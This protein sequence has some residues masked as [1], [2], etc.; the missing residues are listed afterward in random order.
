MCTTDN[1]NVAI[2]HPH[3]ALI[4]DFLFPLSPVKHQLESEIRT[5]QN[6][7]QNGLH[8]KD[9]KFSQLYVHMCVNLAKRA[10]EFEETLHMVFLIR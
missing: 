5:L 6:Y 1:T 9:G 10:D 8:R 4:Y 7:H 2:S 3:T